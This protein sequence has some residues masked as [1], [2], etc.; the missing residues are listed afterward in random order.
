MTLPDFSEF[1]I[2]WNRVHLLKSEQQRLDR[3]FGQARQR[4]QALDSNIDLNQFFF[5]RLIIEDDNSVT[6][7]LNKPYAILLSPHVIQAASR[8]VTTT[9]T[10]THRVARTA[11]ETKKPR[12]P[13]G[14]R[15]LNYEQM[16]APGGLEPP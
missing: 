5:T 7:E 15:G 13:S 6:A 8:H 10:A 16:V 9:A 3:E 1:G 12:R 11:P 14:R 4:L 2:G